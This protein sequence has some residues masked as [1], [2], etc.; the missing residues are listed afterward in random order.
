MRMTRTLRAA[1]SVAAL[2][3]L[4]TACGSD[5]TTTDPAASESDT[6]GDASFTTINDGT[7]TV[8]T[9]S[10]YPP[11]EFDDAESAIG[12]SGFDIE[13]VEAIA[14]KLSLEVSVL[15]T[16]FDALTSGTAMAAGTCDFAI[17]AMTITP[18]RA[19]NLDFSD[20]YYNAAQSLLVPV[21]SGIADLAS[22]TGTLGVQSGTTG[23]SYAEANAPEGVELLAFDAGADLFL[24]LE[25]GTI[26]GILQD[27]PV[28][29]ERVQNDATL[30]VVES[31]QT[32]ENYGM[33]FEKGANQALLDAVNGALADVRADGT[34]DAL[35]AKYFA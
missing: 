16:G 9:E 17:S 1:A 28:N 13:L 4:L 29:V 14:A 30:A 27:L 12:Y 20:G 33:A 18:E 23:E 21:D 2:S 24:A 11:F 35:F 15:S 25:A 34:Y 10:G 3:I 6:V 31:Y 8:C 5:D 19:E 32:D 22:V 7:L 26:V